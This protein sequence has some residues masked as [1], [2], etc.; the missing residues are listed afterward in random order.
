MLNQANTHFQ[1]QGKKILLSFLLTAISISLYSQ[2]EEYTLKAFY[3]E[4][5]TRFVEWPEKCNPTGSKDPF[6]INIYGET[7]FKKTLTDIFSL[8]KIYQREV[9]VREI[10]SLEEIQDCQ[11]VFVARKKQKSLRNDLKKIRNKPVLSISDT[12]GFSQQGVLINFIIEN[13]KLHFEVNQSALT[14]SPLEMSYYML[15]MAKIVNPLNP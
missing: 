3:I 1:F 9:H 6:V 11:I 8:Q 5:F 2:P 10:K 14:R 4:K 12:P 15:N 13:G 7:P